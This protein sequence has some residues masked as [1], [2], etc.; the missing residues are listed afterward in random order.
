MTSARTSYAFCSCNDALEMLIGE[1]CQLGLRICG[2][3]LHA[4]LVP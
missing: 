3:S 2:V 1:G 4:L